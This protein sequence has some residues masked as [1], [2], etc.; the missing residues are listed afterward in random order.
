MAPISV[1]HFPYLLKGFSTGKRVPVLG[2]AL[3]CS[4]QESGVGLVDLAWSLV[5]PPHPA[6]GYSP[7]VG[8]CPSCQVLAMVAACVEKGDWGRR[9]GT[10]P[11]GPRIARPKPGQGLE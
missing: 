4:S 5:C 7:A 1:L 10:D 2:V 6:R 11:G 8:S 9:V 3:P